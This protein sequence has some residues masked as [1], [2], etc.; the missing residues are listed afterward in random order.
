MRRF[1]GILLVLALCATLGVGCAKKA[2]PAQEPTAVLK[3]GTEAAYAPFEFVDEATGDYKGFDIELITAISKALNRK[4]EIHNIAWDGLRPALVNGEID[5]VI[6]AMTITD[7]RAQAVQFSD[8]YFTAGQVICAAEGTDI[9]GITDLVTKRVGVQANTTGHYAVEKIEGMPANKILKFETTPDAFQ[10]LMNGSVDAVV[11]DIPVV[12]E[13]IKN[14]PTAKIVTVGGAF[15]VEYYGIAMNK[16]NTE[17]HKLI[18]QGLAQVKA[19]GEYQTIY[20]KYFG[21]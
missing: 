1:I 2:P 10:A 4:A 13:F 9:K 8:P 17:L 11:A 18:N 15:T 21:K 3:V 5:C 6:S 14:N 16:E 12:L 19:S 20:D 7:E